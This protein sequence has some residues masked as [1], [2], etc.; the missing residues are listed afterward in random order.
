MEPYGVSSFFVRLPRVCVVI[1]SRIAA[2]HVRNLL[3]FI[4]CRVLLC[5]S[6]TVQSYPHLLTDAWV[7]LVCGIP[8]FAFPSLTDVVEHLFVFCSSLVV[9]CVLES[10]RFVPLGL[11][12][13][14][15]IKVLC[16][17]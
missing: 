7:V 13:F 6:A 15:V 11:L 5:E 3:H 4:A 8:K 14:L 2:A 9:K 10:S 1:L 16:I 12:S 17:L